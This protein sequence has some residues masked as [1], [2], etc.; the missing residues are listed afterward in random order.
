MALTKVTELESGII[1]EEAY[2]RVQ[3]INGNK[4]ILAVSLEVFASKQ[5]C[6]EGKQ[7][8]SYMSFTFVPDTSENSLRWDKQA[9][10]HLK[11]LPEFAGS[12]DVLE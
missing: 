9:Y 12:I 5:L 8:I 4:N 6:D 2:I 11:T 1:V 10:D 7:P 3:G